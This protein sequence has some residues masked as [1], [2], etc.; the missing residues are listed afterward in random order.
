MTGGLER[1]VIGI[2]L[3]DS[4]K[5]AIVGAQMEL[6]KKAG[7]GDVRWTPPNELLLPLVGLGEITP[8]HLIRVHRLIEPLFAFAPPFSL[9]FQGVGGTPSALQPRW[10]WVGVE[11]DVEKLAA[12]DAELERA[13]TPLLD[14][15]ESR[16]FRPQ[17]P[18][19]RLR[20][21]SEATRGALGRAIRVAQIGDLGSMLA[22]EVEIMRYQATP[23]GPILAKV[24][25]YLLKG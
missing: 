23:T 7:A 6:R 12:F 15:H 22:A 5:D 14:D 2:R 19:G 3:P 1:C 16:G 13:V 11:G 4:V 9:S 8:E 20:T 18:I 21:E 24:E 17:V 25:A 10:L